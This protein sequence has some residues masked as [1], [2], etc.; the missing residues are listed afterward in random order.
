MQNRYPSTQMHDRAPL[1]HLA[2]WGGIKLV[3]W[4][5]I[6]SFRLDLNVHKYYIKAHV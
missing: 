1:R 6:V 5:A 2:W 4:A 3:L